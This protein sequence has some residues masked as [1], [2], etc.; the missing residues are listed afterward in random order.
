MDIEELLIILEKSKSKIQPIDETLYDELKN[1]IRELEEE[2]KR[3]GDDEILRI[4]DE[5]RT[6]RRIQRRL[7]E[8]RTSKIVRAAWAE[9]CGTASGI[10]G[11]ENLTDKEKKFFRR[12][13][14]L[15]KEFKQEVLEILSVKEE[16]EK[17]DSGYIL[18]R[19]KSDIP[20]FEG[21]DGKTYKLRKEDVV[22]LPA[23][24]AKALIKGDAVEII[25]VKR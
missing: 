20:E 9:V 22:T 11:F 6:L 1:R 25:E 3:A 2:K 12:L 21:V 17:K 13:V 14:E 10:E 24:N 19:V 15:I 7:F 23:L 4:D 16:E 8:V 5:L 18:V